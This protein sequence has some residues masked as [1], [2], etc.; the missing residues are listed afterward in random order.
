M[1]RSSIMHEVHALTKANVSSS[2]NAGSVMRKTHLYLGPEFF[3]NTWGPN[4]QTPI[5]LAQ[6]IRET[7]VDAKLELL[8]KDFLQPTR[9]D[10][11]GEPCIIRS[12]HKTWEVSISIAQLYK[13]LTELYSCRKILRWQGLYTLKMV[14]EQLLFSQE[15]PG[16][17]VR[18]IHL[19]SQSSCADR[20]ILIHNIQNSCLLVRGCAS[21]PSSV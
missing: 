18:N 3:G 11:S 5:I 1:C 17:H 20:R 13:L 19:Q 14:W 4:K 6:M 8:R 2:N 12:E 9:A 21:W 7:F 16:N 10:C 15:S